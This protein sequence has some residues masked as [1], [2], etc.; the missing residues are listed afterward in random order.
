MVSLG[1]LGKIA[2][3][4]EL[5]IEAEEVIRLIVNYGHTIINK[6]SGI[7]SIYAPEFVCPAIYY[8]PLIFTSSR[9]SL[10]YGLADKY[11]DELGE[12]GKL[13]TKNGISPKIIIN[14]LKEILN[15]HKERKYNS[16]AIVRSIFNSL[17]SIANA[18]TSASIEESLLVQFDSLIRDGLVERPSLSHFIKE[19]SDF[20]KDTIKDIATLLKDVAVQSLDIG[21]W[22]IAYDTPKYILMFCTRLI[23]NG[24][25]QL[26]EDLIKI[27]KELE[28]AYNSNPK[29]QGYV[30]RVIENMS[31]KKSFEIEE[32]EVVEDTSEIRFQ[33][34]IM[35]EEEIHAFE[36]V[37]ELYNQIKL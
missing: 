1:V 32:V 29:M 18:I 14:K 10:C 3:E 20:I 30:S 17:I 19:L 31:S 15:F 28:T 37:L 9:N 22:E 24:N 5:E 16:F 21:A 34:R 2:V 11:V 12:F 26:A 6:A 25:E 23:L 13:M 4:R 35:T 33:E 36:K 8:L 7:V 27:L